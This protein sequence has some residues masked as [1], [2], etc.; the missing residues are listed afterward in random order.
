MKR[1]DVWTHDIFL[2]PPSDAE[3]VE[4]FEELFNDGMPFHASAGML[5][6]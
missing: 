2:D 1:S 5:F 4:D 3:F 6:L